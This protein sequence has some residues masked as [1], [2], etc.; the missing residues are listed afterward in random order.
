MGIASQ[1]GA[2]LISNGMN[3]V[4]QKA[5][6]PIKK[7]EIAVIPT[8]T[9]YGIVASARNR[10]AVNKFYRVRGRDS[11]KPCIILCSSVTDLKSLG[12]KIDFETKKLLSQIWPNPVSVILPCPNKSFSYLHRGTKTLA[13]RIP[14]SPKLREFLKKTGPIIAPSANP[15]GKPPAKNVGEAKS[16]FGDS[17]G[18]YVKGEISGKSS[19]LVKIEGG[20]IKVMRKGAWKGLKRL[21]MRS[22]L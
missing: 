5:V 6:G 7:G 10:L 11:K 1:R 13:I 21:M 22:K 14:K 17:A 12:V 20:K 15:E 4:W 8:D 16:Y 9:I 3:K 19:T 18:V 2:F